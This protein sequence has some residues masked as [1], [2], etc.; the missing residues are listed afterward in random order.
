M[1]SAVV[2]AQSGSCLVRQGHAGEQ[3]LARHLS[4]GL[5]DE[6]VAAQGRC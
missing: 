4:A 6:H 5:G 2:V 3:L 1:I